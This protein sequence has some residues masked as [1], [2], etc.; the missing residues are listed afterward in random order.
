MK[1]G[2]VNAQFSI[3]QRRSGSQAPSML[4]AAGQPGGDTLNK[5]AGR[6]RLISRLHHDLGSAASL[7]ELPYGS[8]PWR[9]ACLPCRAFQPLCSDWIGAQMPDTPW[10]HPGSGQRQWRRRRQQRRLS[11]RERRGRVCCGA[12]L[13]GSVPL[14]PPQLRPGCHHQLPVSGGGFQ[15]AGCAVAR[16]LHLRLTAGMWATHACC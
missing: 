16:V 13:H 2:I 11:Q 10:L 12:E 9:G 8:V 15:K 1:I 3:G 6:H 7:L 5:P 14:T 4:N